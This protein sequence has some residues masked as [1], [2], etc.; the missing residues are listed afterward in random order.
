M[1]RAQF[2][3]PYDGPALHTGSMDVNELAPALLATGD[4]LANANRDLNGGKAA[5]STRVRS[6][7]KE[8][9]FAVALVLDQRT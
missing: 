7:F 8:S 4:L 3:W 9:S 5:V 1:S 6:D 2:H